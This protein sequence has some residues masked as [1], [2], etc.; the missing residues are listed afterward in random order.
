MT[1]HAAAGGV[2]RSVGQRAR[3]D[4]VKNV[5]STSPRKNNVRADDSRRPR[6]AF[7]CDLDRLLRRHTLHTQHPT[8]IIGTI[9]T[10][11]ASPGISL[12]QN[13]CHSISVSSPPQHHHQST[14][15]MRFKAKM[16]NDQ[17]SVLLSVVAPISKLQDPHRLAVVYLDEDYV[18]ISCKTSE[19]AGITC[20]AELAKTH[21]F[22]EHRIES[23]ADNVI[24]CQVDLWSFK[25]ALQ[26]VVQS[27]SGGG[28]GGGSF[29]GGAGKKRRHSGGDLPHTHEQQ[30]QPPSATAYMSNNQPDVVLK[31]AKRNNLPCLCLEGHAVKGM[32]EALGDS[33]EIHQAIPVRILRRADMQNHLPP[34]INHPNVQLELPLDR[35]IRPVIDKLKGMG[36]YGTP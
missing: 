35:Q 10:A 26:S 3:F 16:R 29:G 2:C 30:Q 21:L 20:F 18:R 6:A 7:C 25:L 36:Q 1:M 31:L 24:V 28:G 8:G 12:P 34:Q 32:S 13:A 4:A 33:I 17:L 14:N 15:N 27:R 5:G 22:V 23:A 19:Q 9:L 11:L